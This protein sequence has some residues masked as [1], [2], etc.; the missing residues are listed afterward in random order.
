MLMP[1]EWYRTPDYDQA[2]KAEFARRY[3]RARRPSRVQYKVIKAI[4]L[5]ETGE[6]GANQ[7]A[8]E[9]L[10]E[11]T[12][13]DDA[14]RHD[15]GG[16]F[17]SLA[18]L[19]RRGQWKFAVQAL[20]Q[21]IDITSP[22]MSGTSGL[23]DLTLAE[24]LL[25]NDPGS[26]PTVVDLLNSPS[27]ISRIKFSSDLFRYHVVTAHISAARP[28]SR[29]ARAARWTSWKMI[30]PSCPAIP[31]SGE[32]TPANKLSANSTNSP[33]AEPSHRAIRARCRR[34]PDPMTRRPTTKWRAETEQEA[35]DLAA[36]NPR[37]MYAFLWPGSLIDDHSLDAFEDDLDAMLAST[38]DSVADDAILDAVRRLILD[39]NAIHRQHVQVGHP[40]YETG[41]REELCD[42]IDA[43][44][45]ESR[46][47]VAALA[48]RNR[49]QRWELTDRW[50]TW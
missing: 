36:G 35:A 37:E 26:L 3:N 5:M 43:T 8:E 6:P 31:L 22:S 38:E 25:D 44:L 48:A 1:V 42:Y 27:L 15:K 46:I 50:R 39:L 2:A 16:A 24:T 40:G 7:W 32:S 28:R 20:K 10:T 17:E 9:L 34:Y 30:S 13:D 49:F 19:Y 18:G 47:D 21:C 11:I 29:V 33:G 14:Y 45:T 23:P 4:Q 12:A 41:E